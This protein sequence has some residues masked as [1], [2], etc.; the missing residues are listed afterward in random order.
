MTE[1]TGA[2][3]TQILSAPLI[4]FHKQRTHKT[5]NLGGNFCSLK[6]WLAAGQV[7]S[8]EKKPK[9]KTNPSPWMVDWMPAQPLNELLLLRAWGDGWGVV[10][11]RL[12]THSPALFR[13]A[14]A[15]RS[16]RAHPP[17]RNSLE[18]QEGAPGQQ[19]QLTCGRTPMD[20]AQRAKPGKRMRNMDTLRVSRLVL[21]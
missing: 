13:R 8:H 12:W 9:Q 19:T 1:N 7:Q 11:I 14:A 3:I 6:T 10:G 20:P 21:L 2:T 16:H 5:A 15:L 17:K 4:R 18:R